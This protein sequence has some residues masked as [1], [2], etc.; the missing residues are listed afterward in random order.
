VLQS[1]TN[2]V[3]VTARDA[4]RYRHRSTGIVGLSAI[5]ESGA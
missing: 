1:G 3:T 4:A 5:V 2:I